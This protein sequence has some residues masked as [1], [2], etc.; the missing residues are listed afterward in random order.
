[1]KKIITIIGTRPEI[2]KMFPVIKELDK[3]FINTL[4]F[5]GQHYDKN[6]TSVFFKDLGLR[7]PN[8]SIKI[9]N[10]KHFVNEFSQKLIE[11]IKKIKPKAIIYHGDT[12]TTLASSMVSKY[13]F[14]KILNIHIESGYRSA[15]K[16]C[17]EDKIR[18][19]ADQISKVNFTSHH[20]EQKNL[21]AEGIKK[22]VYMVGNTIVDSINLVKKKNVLFK[23]K[24]AYVTLHRSENVDE[25]KRLKKIFIFLNFVSTKIDIIMSLHPRTKKMLKKYKIKKP[26]NI[27][28]VNPLKYSESLSFLNQSS[29]CITD[30]GGLQ[31]E[32]I[33]LG[34]KCFIPLKGTPHIRYIHKNANQLINLNIKNFSPLLQKILNNK[35]QIKK[36][37]QYKKVSKKICQIIKKII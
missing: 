1:M 31:E 13:L 36:F 37:H 17:I 8:F 5:S 24:Y 19:I 26:K 7:K 3:N 9:K 15:D 20:Q 35:I 16:N 4:I 32:A 2:I 21:H 6:M 34:K 27:T 11:Y 12:F 18:K 25:E 28:F 30:S 23:K 14:P 10:K 22:N 29:F 33:I